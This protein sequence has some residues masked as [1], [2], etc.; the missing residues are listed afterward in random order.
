[1]VRTN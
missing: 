1:M